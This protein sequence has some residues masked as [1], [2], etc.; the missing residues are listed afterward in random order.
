MEGSAKKENNTAAYE[1]KLRQLEERVADLRLSRRVLMSLLEQARA[2]QAALERENQRL[3][4]QTASY[5]RRL[6]QQ[7]TR[8]AMLEQEEKQ[9]KIKNPFPI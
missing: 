8:I 6:W 7:N 1:S 4:K 5:C 9:R 3:R 2:D